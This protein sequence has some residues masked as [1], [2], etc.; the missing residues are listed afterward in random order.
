[1]PVLEDLKRRAISEKFLTPK[2]IYGFYPCQSEK[3]SL[4]VYEPDAWLRGEKVLWQRFDFPRGGVQKLCLADYFSPV[5]SETGESGKMDVLALQLVT[6]GEAAS[7]YS[8]ELFKANNY[9]DYLYFHGFS[10]EMAEALAEF[11]H[12]RVREEWGIAAQDAADIKKLF[13]QGY[14]GSRYSPG[15]PACPNLE[16]QRQIFAILQPERIGV[17]L[18]EEFMLEP[19]Q[20]TSALIVHHPQAR[21]FDVR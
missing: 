2:V 13:A 8:Q 14:Q 17:Q 10:V 20:S 19:E 5:L 12:K 18:T 1:M 9:S 16:D 15:Y 4:L 6:V 3:N 11:W 7:G 21:Y